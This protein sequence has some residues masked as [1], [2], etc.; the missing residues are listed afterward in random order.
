MIPFLS[1]AKGLSLKS[2]NVILRA[3]LIAAALSLAG[4][5]ERAEAG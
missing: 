3:L 1:W 4:M 2:A 5:A